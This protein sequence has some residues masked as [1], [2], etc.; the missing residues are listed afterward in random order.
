MVIFN[1]YVK[2]PEGNPLLGLVSNIFNPNL[3]RKTLL[4]LDM[5][6][7]KTKREKQ[8]MADGNLPTI[9]PSIHTVFGVSNMGV[10]SGV[11]MNLT[12]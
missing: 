9:F 6:E 5:E 7:A 2:L 1:S 10:Y 11:L 4:T 8:Y 3:R 12:K